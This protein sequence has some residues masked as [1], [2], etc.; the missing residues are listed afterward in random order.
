MFLIQHFRSFFTKIMHPALF[1]SAFP[2]LVGFFF[3]KREQLLLKL[4]NVKCRSALSIAVFMLRVFF[5]IKN[6]SM[7]KQRVKEKE[8]KRGEVPSLP[9]PYSVFFALP[10]IS[11]RLE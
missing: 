3:V 4:T 7:T 11:R 6:L 9:T 8:R 10:L 1:F 2:N 5:L